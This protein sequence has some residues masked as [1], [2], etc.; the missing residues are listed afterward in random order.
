MAVIRRKLQ[1]RDGERERD[2]EFFNVINVIEGDAISF[3]FLSFLNQLEA[4]RVVTLDVEDEVDHGVNQC[5]FVGSA[6]LSCVG[7]VYSSKVCRKQNYQ[8]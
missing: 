7:D 8:I 1:H 2:L 5:R 3:F 4:D 6:K